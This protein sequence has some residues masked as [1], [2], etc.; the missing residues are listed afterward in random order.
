[1]PPLPAHTLKSFELASKEAL[2]TILSSWS[3]RD[4]K[5]YFMNHE[6]E[7]RIKLLLADSQR[8]SKVLPLKGTKYTSLPPWTGGDIGLLMK[9]TPNQ[10]AASILVPWP[11]SSLNP[12]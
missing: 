2:K 10:T 1:M 8:L 5:K 11:T 6:L 4:S 7:R 12:Y 3:L 9:E